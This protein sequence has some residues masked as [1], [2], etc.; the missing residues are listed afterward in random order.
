MTHSS[1]VFTFPKTG[2]W[3][4]LVGGHMVS[5]TTGSIGDLRLT[6]TD[7][8]FSSQGDAATGRIKSGTGEDESKIYISSFLKISDTT[9]DKVK[10]RFLLA[11]TVTLK[12]STTTNETEIT[13][14]RL[15]E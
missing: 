10:V 11:G 15:G 9:N 3:F 2:L 7:D 12:G 6:A 5:L 14:V 8:N 13:F 4:V 1:G